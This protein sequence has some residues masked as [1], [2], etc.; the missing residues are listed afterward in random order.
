VPKEPS[1]LS[2]KWLCLILAKIQFEKIFGGT[3]LQLIFENRIFLLEI[4]SSSGALAVSLQPF[5]A[6]IFNNLFF[7]PPPPRTF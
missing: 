6:L 2:Q 3:K 1:Y 5:S 4:P 7:P